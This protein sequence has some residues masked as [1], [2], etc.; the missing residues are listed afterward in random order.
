[1]ETAGDMTALASQTSVSPE[2]SVRRGREALEFYEAAFGA[3]EIYL[4]VPDPH[5][6]VERAVARMATVA[7][8]PRGRLRWEVGEQRRWPTGRPG[9]SALRARPV[10]HDRAGARPPLAHRGSPARLQPLETPAQPTAVTR[11]GLTA[12]RRRNGYGSPMLR[13]WSAEGGWGRL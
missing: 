7:R 9:P 3:V 10:D 2:L 4:M 8:D 1:M 13:R 5:A 11:P 6:V 12:A